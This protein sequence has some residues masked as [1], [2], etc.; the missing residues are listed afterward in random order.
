M[1]LYCWLYCLELKCQRMKVFLISCQPAL[2]RDVQCWSE[3]EEISRVSHLLWHH[4]F[5]NPSIISSGASFWLPL[6]SLNDLFASLHLGP[7]LVPS[8][9]IPYTLCYKG[10]PFWP[11]HLCSTSGWDYRGLGQ[12]L[13]HYLSSKSQFFRRDVVSR[14]PRCGGVHSRFHFNY[15]HGAAATQT[16]SLSHFSFK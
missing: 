7:G 2:L 10:C 9:Q 3:S 16:A 13:L 15:S 1:R 6:A 14:S 12:Q 8:F 5:R 11:L 4:C